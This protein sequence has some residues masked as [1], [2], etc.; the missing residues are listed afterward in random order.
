MAHIYKMEEW[1]SNGRW[2]CGDVSA[3]AAGSNTWWY[4]PSLLQIT[5]VE[6]FYLLRDKFHANHFKYQTKYDVFMFSFDTQADCRK[7]KNY[8][9]KIAR[10][11]KFVTY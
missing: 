3:L 5:P 1:V 11:K 2:H 7:F 9:N 4:V 10:D 8:I 6:Y